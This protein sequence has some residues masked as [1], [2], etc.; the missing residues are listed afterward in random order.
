M[1]RNV[2]EEIT[3]ESVS[4]EIKQV[5]L[6][7]AVNTNVYNKRESLGYKISGGLFP[8]AKLTHVKLHKC[9]TLRPVQT[10][11]V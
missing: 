8:V 7:T 5:S 9:L 4:S 2:N 3:M 11:F 6:Q 1:D 10:S